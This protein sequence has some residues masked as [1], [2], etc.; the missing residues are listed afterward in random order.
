[1]FPAFIDTMT[2]CHLAHAPFA[3][4]LLSAITRSSQVPPATLRPIPSLKPEAARRKQKPSLPP[5]TEALNF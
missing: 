1:M 5:A 3:P 4:F 2:I